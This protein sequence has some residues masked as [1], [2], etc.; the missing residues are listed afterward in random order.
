ML[1]KTERLSIIQVFVYAALM[2]HTKG[3][4]DISE[5]KINK[6][7]LQLVGIKNHM[8][9]LFSLTRKGQDIEAMLL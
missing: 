6:D 8:P 7:V 2:L 5:K 4:L 9:S 3:D 1:S